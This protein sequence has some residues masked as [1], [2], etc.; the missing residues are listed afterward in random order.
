MLV[1]ESRHGVE[2]YSALHLMNAALIVFGQ[3]PLQ[4]LINRWPTRLVMV[5]GCGAM[6][7]GFLGLALPVHE[8]S[9]FLALFV[10]T[11]GEMLAFPTSNIITD[12][13]APE[14]MKGSYFG[15]TQLKTLG[16]VLGPI[17]GGYLYQE[18]GR[19]LL[20]VV[21]AATAVASAIVME[22]GLKKAG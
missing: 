3:I 17:V 16:V 22:I 2:L 7:L 21:M 13:L 12:Q 1:A 6:A 11:L 9:L 18:H 8:W 4:A 10:I 19:A 5:T 15:A 20:Y 14:G